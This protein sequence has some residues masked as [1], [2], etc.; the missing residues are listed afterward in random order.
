V[1]NTN[2]L[3]LKVVDEVLTVIIRHSYLGLLTVMNI[4]YMCSSDNISNTEHTQPGF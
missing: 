3:I 4:Y 2:I 1:K